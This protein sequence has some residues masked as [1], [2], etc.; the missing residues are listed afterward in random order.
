MKNLCVAFVLLLTSVASLGQYDLSKFTSLRCGGQIPKDFTTHSSRK[1][2][3]DFEQ[4]KDKNLDK[5]FFLSTRFLFDELL[6][7][8]QILFN[9]PVS[10]YVNKIADYVLAGNKELREELRFYVLRTNTPNAYS[11]DQGIILLT[12]GLIAQ[13]ES[14]AQLAYI[15]CHEISHYTEKHV[16]NEYIETQRVS[17]G[18]YDRTPYGLQ[19]DKISDYSKDLELEADRVGIE[20]FLKTSYDVNEIFAA[21]EVLYYTYLPFDDIRFDTNFF[22]TEHMMVPGTLFPDTI[23][24]ITEE[25]DAD[26]Q[27]STHPNIQKRIDA[28]MDIVGDRS[29]KGKNRFMVSEESFYECQQVCRFESV[30][31]ALSEREYADALY[32]TYLLQQKNKDNRF[33]DLCLV[34]SLYGL[35]KYKN[36]NRFSEVTEKPSSIEGESYTLHLFLKNVSK[37]Q[38]NVIAFRHIY[39]MSK[40]YAGDPVFQ[41]Y[42]MDTKKE[43][44]IN[45]GITVSDFKSQNMQTY[46]EETASTVA[47]FDIDD[48]I[49]KIDE[50]DL[51]KYEKIRMKKKLEELRTGSQSTNVSTEFHLFALHD[52]IANEG[53]AEDLRKIKTDHDAQLAEEQRLREE[54]TISFGTKTQHL[55]IDKLVVVNPIYENYKLNKNQNH[56]KS[57][58]KKISVSDMYARSYNKLDLE[59]ELV[60]SKNLTAGDVD[61][62]NDLGLL[63]RWIGE[64]AEH[65]DIDMITSS[66]DQ[67]M[68]LTEKY[69]TTHFLFSGIFGYKSRSEMTTAHWYGIMFFYTIPIVLIDLMIVHNYFELVALSIDAKED[70]IEFSQVSEVN[71]KG[72][73]SILKAYIYDVLY[74]LSSDPKKK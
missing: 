52:L 30:N 34:K 25:M 4:N 46:L 11:T 50:S 45:S 37:A 41:E 24:R 68:V 60:D 74:Q 56:L 53:L 62:Y 44:A 40:K 51:S 17:R 42:M 19:L 1:Y 69:G 15:L 49:R 64:M 36:H 8:G 22:S 33:L 48:S 31:L 72:I 20:L 71:L 55:G 26:D 23:N 39:D 27:G 2:E 14:E 16:R 9:E 47:L 66:H 38:L 12:T 73:D 29:T 5:D 67:V 63:I 32:M 43:L 57:E 61:E 65:D 18:R 59:T 10:N 35:V 6:L 21:F 3:T 70:E 7:S 28:A 54:S 13:M 58:S